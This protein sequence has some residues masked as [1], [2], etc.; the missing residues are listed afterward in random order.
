MTSTS[1]YGK[2]G[3]R[4]SA[5]L[6]PSPGDDGGGGG[7]GGGNIG[8]TTTT[9]STNSSSGG[10]LA[11]IKKKITIKRL[12]RGKNDESAL[13]DEDSFCISGPTNFRKNDLHQEGDSIVS[14]DGLTVSTAPEPVATSSSS[15]NGSSSSSSSDVANLIGLGKKKADPTRRPRGLNNIDFRSNIA[16]LVQNMRDL[17]EM[18]WN[19]PL[20]VDYWSSRP[21]ILGSWCEPPPVEYSLAC[22]EPAL[23]KGY[24]VETSAKSSTDKFP[25]R[26]EDYPILYADKD[27]RFYNEFFCGKPNET[28]VVDDKDAPCVVSVTKYSELYKVI[29]RTKKEDK[30]VLIPADNYMKALKVIAPEL[31]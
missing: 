8:T 11:G 7:G 9:T 20:L 23:S 18:D 17:D 10:G 5:S 15:I 29:I 14:E 25:F 12:F 24:H 21:Y 4:H 31:K 13:F 28:Y 1:N 3:F 16:G 30:R 2:S 19:H 27:F 26:G 6:S 22:P